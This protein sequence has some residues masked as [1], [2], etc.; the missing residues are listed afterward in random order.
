M[1]IHTVAK[2]SEVTANEIKG[3]IFGNGFF[4]PVQD[5]NSNWIIS[6]Q[7]AQ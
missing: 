5:A 1:E 4:N 2:I 6:L 7:N 3:I